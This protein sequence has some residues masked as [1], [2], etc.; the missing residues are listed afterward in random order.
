M[1]DYRNVLF[2]M[3]ICC[4]GMVAVKLAYAYG[5]YTATADIIKSVKAIA[6]EMEQKKQMSN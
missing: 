6:E 1:R 4:T 3:L 2:G 5:K